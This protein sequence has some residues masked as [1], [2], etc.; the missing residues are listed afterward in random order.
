MGYEFQPKRFKFQ[1]DMQAHK[2]KAF[3]TAIYA[4]FAFLSIS[5]L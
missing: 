2:A 5:T 1:E 4:V 3:V